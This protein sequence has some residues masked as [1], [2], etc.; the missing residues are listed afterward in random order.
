MK[1]F[2]K[3]ETK[4]LHLV[5]IDHQFDQAYLDIMSREEVMKY[6][7]IE[8]LKNRAEAAKI[9]DT[10]QMLFENNR[11][12]RWGIL[13]KETQEFIG[14]VGLNNLKKRD[15]KAEIGFELHP[16][17]WRNGLTMEAVKETLKYSFEELGIFR[18]GAIT[19]PANT[20]SNQLL[21]KA[22]FTLEGELRGYLYQ[23]D[24]SHDALVYS[25]LKSE[26][27]QV[28]KEVFEIEERL[29]YKDHMSEII[30]KAEREGHFD[31]LPGKGK[32]LNLRQDYMNPSEK[33]LYKTLKDNNILPRWIEL[34]NE[35]DTLKEE[36]EKLDGKEKRKKLKEINKKTKEFNFACPPS[37]Q[38]NR[39][40]E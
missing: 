24:Q 31:D 26:W 37:L 5:K 1:Q 36:I 20:A 29:E 27:E 16:S 38:R 11:G 30:K 19:F 28:D 33:Q 32:P 18:M 22:G 3:L 2:P 13:L 8:S 21:K 10:F 40:S 15:K 4:R 6:Y 7:G 25:I 23:N 39:V 17:N 9:I 14:T 12:I 35:I 34:G